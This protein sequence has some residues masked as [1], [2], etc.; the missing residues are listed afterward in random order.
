[1]YFIVMVF[2]VG[3]NTDTHVITKRTHF[4]DAGVYITIRD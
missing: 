2:D 4:T 3:F 1:M